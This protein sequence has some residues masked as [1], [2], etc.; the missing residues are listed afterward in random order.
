MDT[1]ALY[2]SIARKNYLYQTVYGNLSDP[3]YFQ[4]ICQGTGYG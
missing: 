3:E 1:Q 2:Q 4:R